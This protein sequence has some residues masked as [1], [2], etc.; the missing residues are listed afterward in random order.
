MVAGEEY[1]GLRVRG[2]VMHI[3]LLEGKEVKYV[4]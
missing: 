1:I 3:R 2:K 4:K